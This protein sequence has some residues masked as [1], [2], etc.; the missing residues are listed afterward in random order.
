LQG[1]P[2]K[3]GEPGRPGNYGPSGAK[4]QRNMMHQYMHQ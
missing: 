2:G 4:V 1:D 3:D